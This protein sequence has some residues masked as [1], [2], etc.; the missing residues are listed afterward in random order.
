MFRERLKDP[1]FVKE[2]YR[3]GQ[4]HHETWYVFLVLPLSQRERELMTRRVEE[5]LKESSKP[6]GGSNPE[7]GDRA[8]EEIDPKQEVGS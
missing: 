2:I 1:I 4:R 3:I 6:V 7:H 8:R 5:Y